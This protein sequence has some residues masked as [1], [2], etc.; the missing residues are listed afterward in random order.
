MDAIGI[1]KATNALS[2]GTDING[3]HLTSSPKFQVGAAA[4]PGATDID[5]EVKRMEE[6]IDA[7][8]SFF[9]TQANYDP[10]ILERFAKST[11]H[12]RVPILAGFI[13]LKSSNMARNLNAN[14]P[15]VH[16]PDDIVEELDTSKNKLKTS[17]EI[18]AR[19]ITQAAAM[20]DGIHIMAVGWENRIPEILEA[21]GLPTSP[22]A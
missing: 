4:S 13:V 11:Q 8:A 2:R 5:V 9:Q 3:N 10:F 6:K 17:V 1:L 21:A 16:I 14:L 12:L 7:G 15:G 20:F 19:I 22:Q 18:L